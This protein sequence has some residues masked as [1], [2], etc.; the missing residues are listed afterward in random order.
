MAIILTIT[1]PL[2]CFFVF[3]YIWRIESHN[4]LIMTPFLVLMINE[5]FRIMPSFVYASITGISDGYPLFV[6]FVGYLMLVIGFLFSVSKSYYRSGVPRQFVEKKINPVMQKRAFMVIF[7]FSGVLILLGVYLYQGVPPV[8]DGFA[9]L[10]KGDDL[11]Q[12]AGTIGSSRKEITKSHVFGGQYRF[13]GLIR[14]IQGCWWPFIVALALSIYWQ[15]KEKNWL[16]ISSFLFFLSFAFIAGDGTRAPFLETIIIYIILYSYINRISFKAICYGFFAIVFLA[17]L[18]SL[19][20]PKMGF[21]VGQQNFIIDAV[22]KIF[23]RIFIGNS[24]NDVL[25]IEYI[26]DDIIDFRL[27]SLHLRDLK[28]TM[29]GIHGDVPF[30]YELY[31]IMNPLGQGTTYATGTYLTKAYVDFGIF[32]V[33]IIYFFLGLSLGIVQKV[34]FRFYKDPLNLV[35]LSIFSYYCGSV[36]LIGPISTLLV[37]GLVFLAFIISKKII[38]ITHKTHDQ[39]SRVKKT[40]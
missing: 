28:A 6:F 24:I 39:F 20:S 7:I 8:M 38:K 18:M 11:D 3:I 34:I 32:G 31:L 22:G 33:T 25:A 5:L 2:F 17:I 4:A 35:F 26:R 10:I 29:P 27:G 19:Y 21:L 36:V 12:V 16:L 1:I 9:A 23:S 14:T 37:V 15:N 30:A 40:I 13:Q